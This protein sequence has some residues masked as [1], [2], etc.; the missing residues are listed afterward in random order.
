VAE[1]VLE[2]AGE[3]AETE[4]EIR[5]LVREGVDPLGA[6]ERYGMF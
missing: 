5:E 4:D 6:F 3:T 2:R 1:E